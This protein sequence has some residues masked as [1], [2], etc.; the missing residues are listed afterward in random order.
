MVTT[1][2]RLHCPIQCYH[3][4]VGDQPVLCSSYVLHL[5]CK[6]WDEPTSLVL[7]AATLLSKRSMNRD[8]HTIPLQTHW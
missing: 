3:L 7:Q 8:L 5:N 1:V 2:L 4:G 6:G